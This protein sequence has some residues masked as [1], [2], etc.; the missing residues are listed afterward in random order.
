MNGGSMKKMIVSLMLI[1][2]MFAFA[3]ESA[4]SATVG[5]VKY[6]NV[7]TTGTDNNLIALPVSAGYTNAGDIDPTGTNMDVVS[8]WNTSSQGWTA[9]AYNSF[10]GFWDPALPVTTGQSYMINA[11]ANFDLVID[12]P[13]VPDAQYSIITTAGTDNNLI[14]HPLSKA[15][16]TT[17]GAIGADIGSCDVVS[18]FSAAAQGWSA[19]AYNSFFGFW[20]PVLPTEIGKALMINATGNTTWPGTK[21]VFTDG[22]KGDAPKGISRPVYH[23]VVDASNA[24]YDFSAAPYDNITFKCWITARDTEIL[25]EFTVGSSYSTLGGASWVV[26][27]VGNFTTPWAAGDIVRFVVKDEVNLIEGYAE[28]TLDGNSSA[29]YA[30][31]PAMG[32]GTPLVVA[33]PSSIEDGNMPAE[34]KLHQNYPNPFNPTTTIKFDL[35]SN[36]VVK[37]NVYNY[38]GQLVKSLVNGQMNAGYH[39]VN[40]DASSLSAGVYY[41][42]MEAGNSV[43]SNKMVLV[44]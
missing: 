38:N 2:S 23:N 12:G 22:T 20:D 35:T 13:V 7:T 9:S 11:K 14:M 26:A 8:A 42:T 4:P 15:S 27:N 10:F 6:S 39:T 40:F 29:V 1:I 18:I 44:K 16:L 5:Y 17:A 21:G 43:M 30:G 41:Y 3:A 33:T 36:S 31:F 24:V 19:S 28:W 37:L 34:T 25:H 32:T